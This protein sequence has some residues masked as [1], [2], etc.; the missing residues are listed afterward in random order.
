MLARD[1]EKTGVTHV[2]AD[3]DVDGGAGG[4]GGAD[5]ADGGVDVVAAPFAS[6]DAPYHGH[7]QSRS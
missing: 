4:A 2:D 7:N 3:A 1:V 5:D 6:M